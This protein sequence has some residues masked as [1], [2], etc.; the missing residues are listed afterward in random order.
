[1]KV[2]GCSEGH[3]VAYQR[4]TGPLHRSHRT[5]HGD[6]YKAIS[7]QQ[8]LTA[9]AVPVLSS[10]QSDEVFVCLFDFMPLSNKNTPTAAV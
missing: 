4:G 9:I 3:C 8:N 5:A 10:L 1:M 2:K 7:Q 6:L